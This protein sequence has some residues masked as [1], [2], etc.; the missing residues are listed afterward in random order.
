[1]GM[2]WDAWGY[3]HPPFSRNPILV[4]SIAKLAPRMPVSPED[5][6]MYE[7]SIA[8]LIP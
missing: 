3:A 5:L 8:I 2:T 6:A 7:P 1:M 4:F